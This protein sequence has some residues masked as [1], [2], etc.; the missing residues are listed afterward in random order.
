MRVDKHFHWIS[1]TLNETDPIP[2]T[3]N[4]QVPEETGQKPYEQTYNVYSAKWT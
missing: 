1:G 3:E 4:G 2:D